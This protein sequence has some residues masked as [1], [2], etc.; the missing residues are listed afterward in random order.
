MRNKADNNRATVQPR[1][2]RA[3]G[4]KL[5]PLK[6]IRVK[7]GSTTISIYPV[8][9]R[10]GVLYTLTYYQ[11]GERI[12]KNFASKEKALHEAHFVAAKLQSAEGEALT[13][14]REDRFSYVEALNTIKPTGKPLHVAVAEYAAA[15]KILGGRPLIEA[16]RFFAGHFPSDL[17]NKTVSA[18]VAEMKAAKEAD[19]AS[20][21][22]LKD[23]R[24]RF[25]PF[26]KQFNCN[27]SSIT[28]PQLDDWLRSLN[29]SGRSRNNYR[30]AVITF[31]HFARQRGYL[32]KGMPTAADEL[33]TAKEHASEVGIFK[34]EEMPISSR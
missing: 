19:G 12:R 14:K 9:N 34:P 30:A 21:V 3:S 1:A 7:A 10:G 15:S 16:A 2:T 32:P 28:T 29:V 13:L 4:R 23:I 18:V 33:S 22:Y 5:S 25:R 17:P 8:R 24:Y 6:P 20:P 11:N 27:I 26:E 31:F